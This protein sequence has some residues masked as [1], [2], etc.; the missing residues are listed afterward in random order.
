MVKIAGT[1][2]DI[3]AHA[4]WVLPEVS[5]VTGESVFLSVRPQQGTC[6]LLREEGSFP[7]RSSVLAE[8]I[9]FPL[10]GASAGLTIVAFMPPNAANAA[11]ERESLEIAWGSQQSAEDIGERLRQTGARGWSL[12]PGLVICCGWWMG[13]AIFSKKV[14]AGPARTVAENTG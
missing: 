8:G 14:G 12:N 10:C 9:C 2:L 7:L 6:R 5:R 4:G 13:A 3:T 11:L 1:R